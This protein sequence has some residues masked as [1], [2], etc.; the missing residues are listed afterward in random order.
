M[1]LK[2]KSG[3]IITT[4]GEH[5]NDASYVVWDGD[6]VMVTA[7]YLP[8]LVRYLDMAREIQIKANSKAK[9]KMTM[10]SAAI[11]LNRRLEESK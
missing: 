1:A 2:H 9:K 7:S 6:K 3:L 4:R 10:A 11:Q 5:D 8:T